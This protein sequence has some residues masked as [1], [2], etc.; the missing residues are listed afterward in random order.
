MKA[1]EAEHA[2]Q[3]KDQFLAILSHELRTPLNPIMLAVTLLARATDPPEEIG[4]TLEMIREN[5]TLEARLIDDLLDV[6][7]RS[8]AAR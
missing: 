1:A 3:A 8:P 5:V 6:S 7:C 4:P 2:N